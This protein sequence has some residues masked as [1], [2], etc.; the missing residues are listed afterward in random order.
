[1]NSE[2]IERKLRNIVTAGKP[3]S[4]T[5]DKVKYYI[6]KPKIEEI[7]LTELKEG[8]I[9]PLIPLIIGGIAAAGSVAGGAAGIAKAVDDKKAATV[10]QREL[11]RHNRELEKIARGGFVGMVPIVK[12][13]IQN[14]TKMQKQLDEKDRRA[15]KNTLYNL[16]DHIKIEK[17]GDGLYLNPHGKGLY[18]NPLGN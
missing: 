13:A 18:L 16:S 1:M 9:L 17:Q 14:F 11:D 10:R 6:S 5:I 3:K 15:L 7:K 2:E 4:I 12:T 8:G